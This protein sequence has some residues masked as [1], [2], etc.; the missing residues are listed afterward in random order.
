MKRLLFLFLFLLLL[1]RGTPTLHAQENGI[2]QS[3]ELIA[4]PAGDKFL[5]WYGHPGRSYFLQVS[6]AN[7]PLTQWSWA[8]IIENGNDEEISYEVDGTADKGFFRLK[9]TDQVPGPGDTLETADFDGDGISNIDEIAP[10]AP[11]AATD[12][13][14]DDTDGDGLGDKWERDNGLD[15]NDNGGINIAN[16]PDGDADG[17]G[18]SNIREMNTGTSPNDA[19]DFPV[20]WCWVTNRVDA[21]HYNETDGDTRSFLTLSPW[22]NST[23]TKQTNNLDLQ[24]SMLETAIHGMTFPAKPEDALAQAPSSVQRITLDAS[25]Y[26]EGTASFYRV[27]SAPGLT[28]SNAIYSSTRAWIHAPARTTDQEFHFIKIKHHDWVGSQ[29]PY[30]DEET[31]IETLTV[32]VPATQ[33]YSEAVDLETTTQA[34]TG[35]DHLTALILQQIDIVPDDNM[36]GVI[37]DV[38]K[39]V[40]PGSSIKHFVSPKKTTE[41]SQ[42]YVELKATG[43]DAAQFDQ[44]LE[45][46]GGEA[47]SASNKRKVKR[48]TAGCT[49]VKIKVKEGG[50]VACQMDVWVVWSDVTTTNGVPSFGNFMGGAIYDVAADPGWRFVFKIQPASI[51]DQAIQER[52]KLSGFKQKNPPGAG[53]P[54]TI[55]PTLGDGDTADYKWDVSRQYKLT[56]RNPGSIPKLDLQQGNVAAAWI[57]NQPMAEDT[58][59]SFPALDVE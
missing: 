50:A 49:E 14:N 32:T 25:N 9:Y 35:E 38:V 4:V 11:L 42:D 1:L 30:G 45:W 18:V 22:D 44:F 7:N 39:S 59:V 48:D 52:P 27:Q 3:S 57:V 23:P 55:K 12:P 21:N 34:Q 13:L 28:I 37:G 26:T 41:L 36:A 19:N 16:G 33:H 5:R 31:A 46:D 6:D 43:V 47:G 54:Y 56:I 53:K 2:D 17:D 29:I 10:Q 40:Q 51:L 24:P 8:P 58:P 20:E 15:P